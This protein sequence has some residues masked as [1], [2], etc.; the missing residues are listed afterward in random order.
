MRQ[1]KRVEEGEVCVAMCS[2]TMTEITCSG[3]DQ[4]GGVAPVGVCR[5]SPSIAAP[6]QILRGNN[7][8]Y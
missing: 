8:Q 1:E 7:L 3:T 6:G 2:C 5:V 4:S